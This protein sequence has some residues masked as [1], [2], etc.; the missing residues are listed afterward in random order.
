MV[1]ALAN[2]EKPVIAAVNGLAVGAGCSIALACDIIVASSSAKFS[3]SFVKIGLVSDMGGMYFLPRMVGLAKAKELLFTGMALDAKEAHAIGMVNRV[4]P[5][6]DLERAVKALAG[7]MAQSPPKPIGLMKKILNQSSYLDFPSLLELEAQ[8][9]EIC[10][11]TDDHKK[12]VQAFLNRKKKRKLGHSR[13]GGVRAVMP[14][15]MAFRQ[16]RFIIKRKPGG[17]QDR[18]KAEVSRIAI[19]TRVY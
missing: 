16:G 3:Q 11:Q 4:V 8:A 9:Q 10:S 5:G 17:G 6:E 13:T 2:M 12:R 19:G 14:A 7:E 1:V 15:G 18:P